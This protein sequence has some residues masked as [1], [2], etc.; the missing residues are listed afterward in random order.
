MIFRRALSIRTNLAVLVAV[1]VLPAMMAA[2]GVLAYHFQRERTQLIAATVGSARAIRSSVDAEL[3]AAKTALEVLATSP[4]LQSQDFSAFHAQATQVLAQSPINNIA[5]IAPGGQQLLNTALPYG[6]PLPK[7]GVAAMVERV[8]S[9]GQPE[10]SD[11]IVGAVLKRPLISVAVPVRTGQSV[12]HVLSGVVLPTRLQQIITNSS[13]PADRFVVIFD[14][15]GVVA[16]RSHEPERF[17]GKN[18]AP[19]LAA[20][21][22][23]VNEDAIEVLTLEGV[24]VISVFSRSPGTQWGVALGIPTA[25][26]TADLNRSM[27]QLI[28]A[29]AVLLG[30]GLGMAWLMGGRISRAIDKLMQP[31]LDLAQGKA[32]SVSSLAFKEAQALGNALMQTSLVLESTTSALHSS[33]TRMRS[34]LQSATDAIITVDDQQR[35]VLFNAAACAM[36]GY[37]A[38]QAVGQLAPRFIPERFQAQYLAYVEQNR[39]PTE[40]TAVAREGVGL[41]SGG[42]EFPLEI[43]YSNVVVPDGIFHTLIIRD[44]TARVEAFRALERSNL[45]LQRF[46]YVASHDLKTPLRSISGFV[47]ILE[48]NHADKLDE[49]ALALIRRTAQAASRLEQLTEDMLSFA[50]VNSDP[51]PFASVNSH[52]VVQEAIQLLDALIQSTAAEVTVGELPTIMGDRTQLVQLFLNLLGNG[53]KYCQGHAPVV[54]VSAQLSADEWVFAVQDNGI[55]I[56]PKHHQKI[57]E[58]F[59]RLHAQSEYAGTGIG[60][61]V[62]HRIVERHHGKIWVESSVGE[63]STFRFTLPV[64]SEPAP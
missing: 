44:V 59:K 16:A 64:D 63:G 20:R 23:E 33:E 51:R 58:I 27:L 2:A 5:L 7:T 60:L 56:D 39:V 19:G 14:K 3:S 42:E 41:R 31:A 61:A 48:R 37:T 9:T 47:Q 50:R 8:L 32:V 53:L 10:V 55:G 52:E 21:I 24:P 11:L 38:E 57:F 4:S 29:T 36:F 43:S 22:K 54:H 49:N 18:L 46:A 40:L 12:T 17:V 35:V 26:L 30:L 15:A 25:T 6:Q 45:D 34:I 13:Q 62:C 1:C 28:I